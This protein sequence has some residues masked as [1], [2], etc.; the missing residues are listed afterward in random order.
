MEAISI[1]FGV[2]EKA[3]KIAVLPVGYQWNDLGSWEAV[4]AYLPNDEKQNAVKA[5]FLGLETKGC[6]ILSDDPKHLIATIGLNDLVVVKTAEATL[7]CPRHRV[8][9]VKQLVQQIEAGAFSA[10]QLADLL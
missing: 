10:E 8:Q 7:V 1:D 2:L 3:Q 9:Q 4:R 5:K 6:T